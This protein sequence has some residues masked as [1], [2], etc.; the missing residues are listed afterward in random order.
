MSINLVKEEEAS[1]VTHNGSFH[2][3]ELLC[4]VIFEALF[5]DINLARTRNLLAI[6]ENAIVFDVGGGDLDHH[7]LNSRNRANGFPYA[8]LGLVWERYG[9]QYLELNGCSNIEELHRYIDSKIIA[10][11]DAIDNGKGNTDKTELTLSDIV[12][13]F[14]PIPNAEDNESEQF[15]KA[16]DLCKIVW[17]NEIKRA[18]YGI[19]CKNKIELAIDNSQ[20]GIMVLSER[21]TWEEGVLN[22][23]NPKA[24]EI[25]YVIRPGKT[26]EEGYSINTV[27]IKLGSFTGRLPFPTEWCGKRDEELE[28]LSGIEGLIFCH[29]T[30]F[31][32]VCKTKT[33]AIEAALKSIYMQSKER[34]DSTSEKTLI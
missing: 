18:N 4:L 15:L 9:K 2:P 34:Y 12:E 13:H 16:F 25:L 33:K 20:N 6:K 11:L 14:N 32:A 3:D 23:N 22:S 21:I 29:K 19:V 8:S 31:M 26:T 30:G 24:K 10:I 5:K 7:Q 17:N 27:P 1:F 28:K